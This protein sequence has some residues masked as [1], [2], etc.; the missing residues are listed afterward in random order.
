[1]KIAALALF[2]ATQVSDAFLMPQGQSRSIALNGY[3]DDLTDDLYAPSNEPDPEAESHEATKMKESDKDRAGPGSWDDYVEFDSFDGGDGQMGVAGDGNKK[4]E[5][6]DMS[7]MAKS[8]MM[9]AKNAWGTSNGY[10]DSLVEKGVD[11]ARAQQLENW[12]NQQEVLKTKN[13][14]KY[15]VDKYDNPDKDDENWRQ[16]AAFGVERNEEFDLDEAFGAVAVSTDLEGV[17][18]ITARMGGAPA[19]HEFGLKNQFMGYAD[20]R[21]AFT[22]ETGSEWTVEPTEGS[23]TQRENTNFIVRF[24]PQSPSVSEGYLVIETE[25]FKKT[26][27]IVGSTA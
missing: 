25:D 1:M 7:T 9:S 27:K 2:Y 8:K 12:H 21:A 4:L 19:I 26:W 16:L 22:S 15:D 23:L 11:S 14:Q 5:G 18:E 6:F 13:A 17:I 3:L 20:F 24:R 10:A